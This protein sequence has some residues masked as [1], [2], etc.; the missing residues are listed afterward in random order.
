[1]EEMPMSRAVKRSIWGLGAAVVGIVTSTS[2]ALAEVSTDVSGSVLVFPKIIWDGPTAT[3]YGRDTIVQISNTSNNMVHAH[4]FY[5]DARTFNGIPVW[6]VTDFAIWL[7]KQQP[8]H[9]VVSQGRAVNPTD[10][11]EEDGSGLD[12]GAIPP[13]PEGFEGELKCIQVDASG[14]PFGGNNL[15]GEAV[16]R[17]DDGDVSK[18]NAI[19]ILANPDLA[20]GDPALELRLDNSVFNDGEYN[21]C[22]QTTLLNH[23]VDGSDDPVVDE[24]N[25]VWCADDECPIRT[26][27]TLVPCTQDFENQNFESVTVQFSIVNEL[28]QV[29]SASTTVACWVN[30]RLAD[31]DAPTGRCTDDDSR[32]ISDREC[33][34]RDAGF[35]DKTSVFAIGNLGT[36][37]AFTRI[38]PV[39]LDGGVLTVAEEIHY[40]HFDAK[41]QQTTHSAWAAWNPQ[42]TGNRYDATDPN[43]GG[44]PGGPVV[45]VITVPDLF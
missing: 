2:V 33:I 37:T 9:W 24:F 30:F 40:N 10:G 19:A 20:G 35:C 17:R 34:L 18:H 44:P 13:V 5:V 11:Y 31:V 26:Y 16:L 8:T 23:F 3:I 42:T 22:P 21:S 12:P 39:A 43:R 25:E 7:T 14:N 4:C 38:T 36:S 28:E 45:D 6:Q 1:M 29:F 41:G 32:C 27:L 15:K